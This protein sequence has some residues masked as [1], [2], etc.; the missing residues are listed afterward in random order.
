[1]RPSRSPT[2][3]NA[4]NPIIS[5]NTIKNQMVMPGLN[6]ERADSLSDGNHGKIIN[7][8]FPI[9]HEFLTIS[10]YFYPFLG[11]FDNNIIMYYYYYFFFAF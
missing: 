2:Q 7:V 11:Y 3:M 5:D 4:P 9:H 1:M 8:L 10:F 6:H